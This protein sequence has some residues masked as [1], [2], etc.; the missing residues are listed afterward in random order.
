MHTTYYP[1]AQ[2]IFAAWYS[3]IGVRS[4]QVVTAPL[5]NARH[6]ISVSRVLADDHCKGFARVRVDGAKTP[7]NQTQSLSQFRHKRIG[8]NIYFCVRQTFRNDGIFSTMYNSF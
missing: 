8:F 7:N 2:G 3:K 5:L 6:Q 4:R 1:G